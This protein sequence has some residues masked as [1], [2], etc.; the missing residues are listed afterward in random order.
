MTLAELS[1][2]LKKYVPLGSEVYCAD[3]LLSNKVHLNIK[4]PRLSKLGDYRP[5]HNGQPHRISLNRDLNPYAFLITFLHEIAHLL[6]FEKFGTKV[7]PHGPEWKREF[8]EVTEPMLEGK[9]FPLDVY[10]ALIKYM[11][12]PYASSCS[13]PGLMKVLHGYDSDSEWAMVDDI[14]INGRFK[15]KNGMEFTKL[16]KKR[17]RYQCREDKTGREYLV[18]G[19]SKCKSLN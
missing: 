5:K 10:Q 2:N 9:I 11:Q 7:A 17:T 3:L 12:N 16:H 14:S 19:V 4:N 15:L 1:E 13:D 8:K 18:P 6:N